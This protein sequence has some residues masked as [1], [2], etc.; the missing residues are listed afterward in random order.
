LEHHAEERR[1][2]SEVWNEYQVNI[3]N[4]LRDW[5]GLGSEV[6]EETLNRVIGFIEVNS[7]QIK[8]VKR[9]ELVFLLSSF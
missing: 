1:R 8:N 9:I 2:L 5:H 6:T 3:V 7:F 4:F